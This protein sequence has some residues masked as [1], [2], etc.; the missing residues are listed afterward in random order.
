MEWHVS[1]ELIL[2]NDSGRTN[3]ERYLTSEVNI[4]KRKTHLLFLK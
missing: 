4:P 2:G 1:Y 3:E